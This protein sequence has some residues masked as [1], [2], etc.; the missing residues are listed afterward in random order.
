MGLSTS[1][2]EKLEKVRR[3][4]DITLRELAKRMKIP[5][6]TVAYRLSGKGLDLDSALEIAEAL[7]E[8]FLTIL[9]AVLPRPESHA[10]RAPQSR[11]THAPGPGTA[12]A[13]LGPEE[14]RLRAIGKIASFLPAL[15]QTQLGGIL[16]L[17]EG[18]RDAARVIEQSPDLGKKREK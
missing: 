17:I 16:D 15:N 3:N 7:D 14:Q 6:Q 9:G 2:A 18:Y 13:S 11:S 8:D 1:F 12:P 4:K 5:Y 10:V